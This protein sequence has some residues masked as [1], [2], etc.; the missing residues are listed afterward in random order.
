[1]HKMTKIDYAL[2]ESV[3][4]GDCSETTYYDSNG[5]LRT[6]SLKNTNVAKLVCE[7]WVSL[8][9][10]DTPIVKVDQ[11]EATDSAGIFQEFFNMYVKDR[12]IHFTERVFATGQG[13]IVP[14][15]ENGQVKLEF[16]VGSM[17]QVT[18]WSNGLAAKIV[19]MWE[20]KQQPIMTTITNTSDG[21]TITH[22][23]KLPG[24]VESTYSL[25]YPIPYWKPNTANNRNGFR[26]EDVADN[27]G[28]SVFANCIDAIRECNK[29]FTYVAE[30]IIKSQKKIGMH[31]DF[32]EKIKIE[33]G[34]KVKRI[35]N[36]EDDTFLL[37]DGEDFKG[38][39]QMVEGVPITTSIVDAA[40]Y[41]MHHIG[42]NTGL[43]DYYTVDNGILKTASEAL[44]ERS[45]L[46]ARKM[47]HQ[48]LITNNLHL[49]LKNIQNMLQVEVNYQII[50]NDAIITDE[51]KQR[52]NDRL[53]VVQGLLPKWQYMV[54]WQG[55]TKE[56]ALLELNEMSAADD[57]FSP[58]NI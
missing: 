31:K 41:Y 37:V 27:S 55:Y 22:H 14:F 26:I 9:Y 33:D 5:E 20:Y 58:I 23:G 57:M 18:E 34:K 1:M 15:I 39:I 19:Y 52:D 30:D 43:K 53:D 36:L 51:T 2:Y 8:I 3:Y 47:L 7:D 49:L 32:A 29:L 21:C 24:G 11:E 46:Y 54:R 10:G 25:K 6:R 16:L 50:F 12:L 28:L 48:S 4:A 13:V 56:S 40:D 45:A 38:K 17:F 35:I 44:T 42:N